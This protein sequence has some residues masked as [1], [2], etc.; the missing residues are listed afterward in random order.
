[1]GDQLL[2][3][4]P[5]GSI[6][7]QQYCDNSSLIIEMDTSESDS[8]LLKYEISGNDL[9]LGI[10]I[11]TFEVPNDTLVLKSYIVFDRKTGSTGLVGVWVYSRSEYTVIDGT[12]SQEMQDLLDRFTENMPFSYAQVE[13]TNSEIIVYAVGISPADQFVQDWNESGTSPDSEKYDITIQKLNSNRLTMTGRKSGEIVTLT[14]NGNLDLTYSSNTSGHAPYTY[15]NKPVTCPNEPTPSWFD[16]FLS[17]NQKTLT[18]TR[19]LIALNSVSVRQT[20]K[21]LCY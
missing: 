5:G 10:S 17:D 20:L 6:D 13:F 9:H 19:G 3:N 16:V 1:M 7:T 21:L 15:Y 11:D 14:W 2:I 12:L 8:D 4:Y 18:K